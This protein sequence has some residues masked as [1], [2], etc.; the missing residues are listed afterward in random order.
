MTRPKLLI[1]VLFQNLKGEK[2]YYAKSPAP[3]LPGILL[4]GMTPPIVDIE[5]LHEM[6]RPIDYST[7]ADFVA[8]SFMDY[9]SPHAYEVSARFRSLGKIVVGGGR[10]ATTHPD[11]VQPH[12]DSILVGEAQGLWPV[13]VR[14]LVEGKLRR[15]YTAD[16]APSLER[17]P[18]PRYDLVERSFSVPM[19]TEASRGCPH[20][21]TYCALNIKRVPYRMRPVA[22]V[23]ADLK[24][25]RGVPWHR[26]KMAMILDNNL[27]G[28]LSYAKELL[29]EIAKLDFWGIGT[30]FSIE[31]LRDDA[32]VEALVAARCRM[33]FIGM[34]S[35]NAA[36]LGGV[37]KRQNRVEEY[38]DLFRKLHRRGIL[39]F[40]GL[41]FALEA[42]SVPYYR[43][44]P[45]KLDEIGVCAILPS[46]SIPIYGTPWYSAVEEEGRIID[47][48][49]SHYE[50]D[51]LVFRHPELTEAEVFDAYR[52][53]N[54]DF[55]SWKKMIFR[56]LRIIGMQRKEEPLPQ[57]ALKL[58]ILT[59]V[60]FKLSIFQRHH[61]QERVFQESASRQEESGDATG[62]ARLATVSEQPSC[63]Y[64]KGCHL[65]FTMPRTP[66]S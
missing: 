4:A 21:C 27:G 61:A 63:R 6:I 56:W 57:F 7:E 46:I 54:R 66:T 24:N 64:E 18:P 41:M 3:P 40:A 30:Q 33:A 28:D 25:T 44:L 58:V 19:V 29:G 37:M 55:Y 2:P 9:L 10:F 17:I 48:D 59:S 16:P 35:L 14:D 8:I 39:T 60:Y 1:I 23:I 32:F 22:D 15:R 13:M 62:P 34:E 52:R 36:S 49:I 45:R 26:R 51:H 65:A 43:E 5:V 50:G 42:D 31:C 12:F 20:P 53:V 38:A 11:E 47:R